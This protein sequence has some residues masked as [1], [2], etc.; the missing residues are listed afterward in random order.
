MKNTQILV[1]RGY[2]RCSK[3]LLFIGIYYL[4]YSVI[5]FYSVL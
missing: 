5:I 1:Y 4:F 2:G 3:G